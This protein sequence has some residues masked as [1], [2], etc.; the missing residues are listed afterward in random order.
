MAREDN[1]ASL[2]ATDDEEDD[3]RPLRLGSSLGWLEGWDA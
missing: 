1:A 3:P 2:R